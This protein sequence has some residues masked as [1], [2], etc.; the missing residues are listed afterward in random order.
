M[1]LTVDAIQELKKDQLLERVNVELSAVDTLVPLIALPNG[2]DLISIEGYMPNRASYRFTFKTKSIGDFVEYSEEFEQEGSK[3]FVDSD[4]MCARTI[5]DLGT[6]I[7]PLHQSH[8]S[9][10]QLDKTAAFKAMLRVDG[11]KL[12][13]KDASNFLDDWADCLEV[14]SQDGSSMTIHQASKRLREIT[15]EQKASIDSKVG[16]FGASMSSFEKIEA[17]G[18]EMIPATMIFTCNPYHGLAE[19]AFLLRVSILTGEAKPAITLRIIKLETQN[20]AIAEEFKQIL[21]D[22]FASSE[23]KTFIGEG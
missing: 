15:I 9:I 10:L 13:Q 19:R 5:L 14:H 21:T 3:C 1:S 4:E 6:E 12:A 18:Q 11:I 22:G 17:K 7:N 2:I 16:D 23:I 8:K 20:E